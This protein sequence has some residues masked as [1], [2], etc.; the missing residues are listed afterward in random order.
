MAS[1]DDGPRRPSGDGGQHREVRASIPLPLPRIP[2]SPDGDGDRAPSH[3]TF[4]VRSG[5]RRR[6]PREAEESVGRM[7]DETW[8]LEPDWKMDERRAGIIRPYGP[9]DVVRLR[10]TI[11]IRH[12]L[13]EAAAGRLWSLYRPEATVT[14]QGALTGSQ[15]IQ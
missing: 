7:I 12:T 3:G 8:N 11:R 9:E 5:D 13:A 6:I 4:S 2:A 14:T 10:G 15:A 1:R